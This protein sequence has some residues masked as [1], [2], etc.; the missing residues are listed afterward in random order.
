MSFVESM[1]LCS[2]GAKVIYPPTIYPVFYKNIPIKILNTFNPEAPGTLITEC[3]QGGQ[4]GVRGIS[5]M[6]STSMITI[7]GTL[8]ENLTEINSRAFN[9]LARRGVN[10]L[11]V[12]NN[13]SLVPQFSFVIASCDSNEAVACLKEEFAPE[14]HNNRIES[15]ALTISRSIIA[16]VGEGIKEIK[17][18]SGV[19]ESLL[20]ANSVEVAAAAESSVETTM[21]FVVADNDV[22]KALR[23][24]H[25]WCFDKNCGL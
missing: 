16:I 15:V 19:I 10:I 6:K 17:G 18:L 4:V 3:P 1:E 14:L 23:I 22:E 21:T 9:S 5:S 25:E 2:F 11:M 12:A 24:V 13:V 8:A 7:S 20:K